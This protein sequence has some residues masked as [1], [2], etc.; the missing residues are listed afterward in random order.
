MKNRIA[1]IFLTLIFLGL[2][3]VTSLGD[4][5]ENFFD[6]NSFPST[7]DEGSF[8]T[9]Y[10]LFDDG[11]NGTD[12]FSL[13]GITLYENETEL[14]MAPPSGT[15]CPICKGTSFDSN[16]LCQGKITIAGE[17]F[18]CGYEYDGFNGIGG[19]I[20]E[21]VGNGFYV[22]LLAG[23]LYVGLIAYRIILRRRTNTELK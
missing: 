3:T 4:E 7:F 10:R 15:I 18:P 5:F 21:P 2:N 12:P 13:E 11:N 19:E 16:G 1:F 17:E 20:P 22:L 8:I 9:D 14:K 23:F 6:A